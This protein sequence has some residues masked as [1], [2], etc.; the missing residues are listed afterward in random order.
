MNA[1]V[2]GTSPDASPLVNAR[3]GR[4]DDLTW[5][6]RED[7]IELHRRIKRIGSGVAGGWEAPAVPLE[8]FPTGS[9]TGIVPVGQTR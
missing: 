6:E 7:V 4:P 8:M 9:G 3:T 1:I 5:D 2:A